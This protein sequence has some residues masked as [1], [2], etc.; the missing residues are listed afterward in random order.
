MSQGTI[1]F[2]ATTPRIDFSKLDKDERAVAS[3]LTTRRGSSRA[4]K[5][6]A[7]AKAVGLPT[8]QVQHIVR[9][10]IVD[11]GIPIGTSM[12]EPYGNYLAVTSEERS[13]IAKLH[14][15]RAEAEM[16]RAR[17]FERIDREEHTR[18]HQTE[19]GAA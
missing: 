12:R 3:L 4:M 11:H 19:L 8:R 9:S 14:R 17:V 7:I 5:V 16:E 18:R 6:P 2:T 13:A 15:A 1:D 10:L